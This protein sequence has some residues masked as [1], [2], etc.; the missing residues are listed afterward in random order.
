[1]W[2]LGNAFTTPPILKRGY[3]DKVERTDSTLAD[4]TGQALRTTLNESVTYVLLD[5]V[6]VYTVK[7]SLQL[8]LVFNPMPYYKDVCTS[9]Q[10]VPYITFLDNG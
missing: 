10:Y 6:R 2:S 9:I 8:I 1:M 7:F 4:Q 5:Y 3:D